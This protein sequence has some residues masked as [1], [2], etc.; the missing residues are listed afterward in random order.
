MRAA[1]SPLFSGA[2]DRT[3][4]VHRKLPGTT[5]LATSALTLSSHMAPRGRNGLAAR[6]LRLLVSTLAAR[7]TRPN[8]GSRRSASTTREIGLARGLTEHGRVKP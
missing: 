1:P 3:R 8:A 7:K 5:M 6:T 2:V 4:F